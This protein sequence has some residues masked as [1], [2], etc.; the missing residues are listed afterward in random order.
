MHWHRDQR[1][2]PQWAEFGPPH[3]WLRQDARW[4]ALR[5]L[6]GPPQP[7]PPAAPCQ[8]AS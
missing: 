6:Q 3:V 2:T 8:R 1:A 7:L 5:P 4:T